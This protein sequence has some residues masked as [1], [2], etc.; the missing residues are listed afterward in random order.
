MRVARR[1]QR[2]VPLIHLRVA[3]LLQRPQHQIAE[4]ALLGL[5]LNA[6]SQLLIHPWRHGNVF[7]NFMR[8][9]RAARALRFAPVATRLHAFHR[10]RPKA[11]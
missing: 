7:G 9:R 2:K 10:K 3:C 8:A 1:G 11:K 4:N 5:A 6:R